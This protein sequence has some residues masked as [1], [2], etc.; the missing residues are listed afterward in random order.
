M[1]A[2]DGRNRHALIIEDEM[3][4]ALEVES[5]LAELGFS[6]FD[7]ADTPGEAV[8]CALQRRPDLITAD[9]RII[10]G[11]GMEAV[12]KIA[13]ALGTIPVVFVTGNPDM[14]GGRGPEVVEKPIRAGRLEAACERV[15][16]VAP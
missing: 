8:A 11:T 6:T 9:A 16:G 13:D 2:M 12:D 5:I 10:G 3:L 14:V 1:N 7:I 4:I 15:C